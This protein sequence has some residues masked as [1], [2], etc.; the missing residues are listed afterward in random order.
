MS[1]KKFYITKSKFINSMGCPKLIWYD[2]HQPKKVPKPSSFEQ[3][4]MSEG[5][6]IGQLAQLHP[7]YKNGSLVTQWNVE[8]AAAQTQ[9]FLDNPKVRFIYE[10][11]FIMPHPVAPCHHEWPS[12][13]MG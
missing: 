1:D 3:L 10:A 13:Y 12:L 9:R 11:T 7:L 5:T 8:K 6:E 4:K 2:L